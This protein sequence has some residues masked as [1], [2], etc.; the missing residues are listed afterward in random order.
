LLTSLSGAGDDPRYF[1]ISVP[2]QPDN[3]GG[4]PGDD[5]GNVVG[6]ASAKLGE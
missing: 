3:S 4:A 1:Q 5:H 2:F 6:V